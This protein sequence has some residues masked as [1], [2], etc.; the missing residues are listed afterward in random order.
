VCLLRLDRHCHWEGLRV[1]FYVLANIDCEIRQG[2]SDFKQRWQHLRCEA[3]SRA[4]SFLN[5][6]RRFE[7]SRQHLKK[8]NFSL[9]GL[10]KI[11]FSRFPR[12]RR[13]T[14]WVDD[15]LSSTLN[16]NLSPPLKF[17][18]TDCRNLH[19]RVLSTAC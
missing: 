17:R 15:E 9:A 18:Q 4:I 6:S 19:I 1:I 14:T 5:I 16:A 7:N 11:H 13:A 3:I 10:F 2:S 8:Y 12:F